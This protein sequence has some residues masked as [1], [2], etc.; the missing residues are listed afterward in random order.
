[1]VKDKKL[2]CVSGFLPP[3]AF[4][5]LYDVTDRLSRI[6]WFPYSFAFV[7]FLFIPFSSDGS[8]TTAQ[9]CR[10][11]AVLCICTKNHMEDLQVMQSA[12]V[13]L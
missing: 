12:Y 6:Q 1:M 5:R 11:K 13:S 3:T 2:S 4:Y 9:L 7:S 8:R 10:P